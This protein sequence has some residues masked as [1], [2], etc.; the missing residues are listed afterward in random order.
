MI[1]EYLPGQIELN[2][3]REMKRFA[4]LM[5]LAIAILPGRVSLGKDDM[6]QGVDWVQVCLFGRY[7]SGRPS[8]QDALNGTRIRMSFMYSVQS[9]P[10]QSRRKLES[11]SKKEK[12]AGPAVDYRLCVKQR[13]CDRESIK[14][15]RTIDYGWRD[16]KS[17]V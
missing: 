15:K 6:G 12:Q 16:R 4:V 11:P 17:V 14:D 3:Q 9:R 5:I 1:G 7:Q 8:R 10:E 13:D 2:H